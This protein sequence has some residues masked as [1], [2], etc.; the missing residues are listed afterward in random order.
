MK[1][2]ELN[3]YANLLNIQPLSVDCHAQAGQNQPVNLGEVG[4]RVRVRRVELELTQEELADKAK[5]GLGTVQALEAAA[6]R[7]KPRQTSTPKLEKIAKA[8][9]YTLDA[10]LKNKRDVPPAHPLLVDLTDEDL[11]IARAY[12]HAKT[13]M[14]QRIAGLLRDGENEQSVALMQRIEKLSPME[15]TMIEGLIDKVVSG[16]TIAGSPITKAQ[17]G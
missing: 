2:R 13:P 17:A 5:V 7:K 9:G 10:L 1:Y 11:L 15:R 6:T 16:K 8:L 12:H 4:K 3:I 14:R